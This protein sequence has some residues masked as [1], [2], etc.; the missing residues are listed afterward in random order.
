MNLTDKNSRTMNNSA[1]SRSDTTTLGEAA[2]WT[3]SL[4]R[5]KNLI[6]KESRA[7]SLK[8]RIRTLIRVT[9][10]GSRR[11]NGSI[12]PRFGS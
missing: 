5:K 6:G 2:V 10:A 9:K 4:K 12:L 1:P 11:T 3:N 8:S 7:D